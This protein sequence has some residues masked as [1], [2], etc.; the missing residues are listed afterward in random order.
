MTQIGDEGIRRVER[1]VRE[2]NQ[3]RAALA[4]IVD[5]VP[6]RSASDPRFNQPSSLAI[7]ER[8]ARAKVVLKETGE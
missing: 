8:V 5:L 7:R 3:L 2:R 1:I 6:V 4:D